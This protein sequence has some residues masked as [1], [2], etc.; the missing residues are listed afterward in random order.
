[1]FAVQSLNQ[2]VF[3]MNARSEAFA[4]LITCVIDDALIKAVP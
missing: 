2:S 4:P 1:M 3:D